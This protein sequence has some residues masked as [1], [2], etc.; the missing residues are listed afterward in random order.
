LY[1]EFYLPSD[2]PDRTVVFRIWKDAVFRPAQGW[3]LG[4]TAA[5]G[6]IAVGTVSRSVSAK[7]IGSLLEQFWWESRGLKSLEL[8][9]VRETLRE[10]TAEM[11]VI[12]S[13][14]FH[15]V[16]DTWSLHVD[17]RTGEAAALRKLSPAA[18]GKSGP[19]WLQD[20]VR[21]PGREDARIHGRV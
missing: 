11:P 16:R 2:L 1:F 5:K 18:L 4:D 12:S 6:P 15:V 20:S 13:D 14:G 9:K 7:V 19:C 17:R 21:D 8:P 3:V 10:V